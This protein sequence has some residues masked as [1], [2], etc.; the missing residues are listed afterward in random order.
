MEPETSGVTAAHPVADAARAARTARMHAR[1]ATR[2]ADVAGRR[3]RIAGWPA[4][5]L[6]EERRLRLLA[7]RHLADA[8]RFE[9]V[10]A[11]HGPVAESLPA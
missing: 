3:A 8:R 10:T 2:L 7:V 4:L 6:N 9:S 1:H 5:H 11:V